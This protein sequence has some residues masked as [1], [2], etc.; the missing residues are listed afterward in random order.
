MP[1]RYKLSWFPVV[2]D[3]FLVKPNRD[4]QYSIW[5][6][7]LKKSDDASVLARNL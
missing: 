7:P 5:L 1:P 4:Y 6:L 2:Y 3:E